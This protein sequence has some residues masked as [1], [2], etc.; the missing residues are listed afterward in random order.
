MSVAGARAALCGVELFERKYET[1][2]V[3]EKIIELIPLNNFD[4]SCQTRARLNDEAVRD[5][6]ALIED[7][8]KLNPGLAFR[9]EDGR[10][11]LSCG[12]HRREAYRLTGR[13]SMPVEIRSGSPTQAIR[14]GIS[15]NNRHMGVRLTREDRRMA[16]E[17]LLTSRPD[18]SNKMIAAIV[19][20]HSNSVA[21]YRR[22]LSEA[23][24]ITNCDS[25]LGLDGRVLSVSQIGRKASHPSL[26]IVSEP[27]SG[28]PKEGESLVF[29]GSEEKIAT[30]QKSRST[31]S[32]LIRS[33]QPSDEL[34]GQEVSSVQEDSEMLKDEVGE[35]QESEAMEQGSDVT[36]DRATVLLGSLAI[37]LYEADG[38]LAELNDIF[39]GRLTE[40]R[41][42]LRATISTLSRWSEP[43]A[44]AS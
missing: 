40:A 8:T 14:E 15:D 4:L 29:G 24:T 23:A 38:D 31:D 2:E 17:L 10:L 42:G 34:Q 27:N 12:F 28:Q 30:P 22:Q 6:A 36:E 9:T 44:V 37:K 1:M 35:P 41:I 21:S 20:V 5:Y 32:S 18:F 43:D 25:R 3:A 26:G 33:G 39:P 7:G 19:G 16:V 13:D 11:I